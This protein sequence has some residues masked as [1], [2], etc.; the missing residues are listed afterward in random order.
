MRC[1]K[2]MAPASRSGSAE[3]FRICWR[4]ITA[5]CSSVPLFLLLLVAAAEVEVEVVL[6]LVLGGL[7][8]VA[9]VVKASVEEE[10][11]CSFQN[12]V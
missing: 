4:V 5:A 8:V 3:V 7:D 6:V 12:L 9:V 11:T 10:S 1:L 2:G